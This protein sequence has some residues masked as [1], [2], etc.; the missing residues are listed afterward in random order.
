MSSISSTTDIMMW[1]G[2][3]IVLRR[4]LKWAK[5]CFSIVV[6]SKDQLP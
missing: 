6:M 5:S 2:K 1:M 4:E 3:M